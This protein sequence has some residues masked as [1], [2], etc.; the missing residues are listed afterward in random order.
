MQGPAKESPLDSDS[1]RET[2]AQLEADWA[3]GLCRHILNL[4]NLHPKY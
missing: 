1:N 4:S 3:S 2:N